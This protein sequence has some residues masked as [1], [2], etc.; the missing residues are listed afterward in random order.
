MST[1]AFMTLG[2]KVNQFETE[3][4]EGLFKRA[5]YTIGKFD[6]PADAYVI[7]TCSVTSLG[8]RKS[9][10]IIRRAHRENPDAVIA[11]C[12]CYAQTAPEAIQSIEGVSVVLGT[13]ERSRIVEYVEQAMREKTQVVNVTDVMQAKTFEDIPL[14]DMPERTRAFLK[15]EDGCENFC[16]YCIIPYARGPVKSRK[17]IHIREEAEKLV[18]AGFREIVLTGI[19]LGAYGRDLAP[20]ALADGTMRKITLADAC[21]E[22]LAVG[23]LK[24]LRLGSLESLELSPELFELIRTDERFCAHLHLPLQ[25]GSDQ[26]LHDMN[27]HYDT[28][29]FARLIE[30]VEREVPGIAVSTDIIVG[31]PGETEELFADGLAFV[32][33]MNFSRMHVFPYSRRSG[34][35]AAKRKDQIPEPVKKERVHRMQ[36]LADRKAREF[37]EQF[38]GRTMRVLFETTKDGITDGLTD[39]YIRVYTDSPVTSGELYEVHIE[40]LYKDGVWGQVV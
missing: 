19:H 28:A 20:I 39:N 26:V 10:Q 8:D 3:T 24:R 1:V 37:H 6:E 13:K 2:C 22:V 11:V 25:A 34:T 21:R 40:K 30:N 7:N 17:P 9:R 31:F 16:S 4:M 29:E 18:K 14:Y 38:L 35:P 33:R 5:G 23:G 36:A 15:I 32:E 12:G 27:R